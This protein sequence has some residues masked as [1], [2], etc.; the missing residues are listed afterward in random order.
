MATYS[1]QRRHRTK[2]SMTSLYK[3]KS[4]FTVGLTHFQL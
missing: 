1:V 2:G 4:V 3:Q